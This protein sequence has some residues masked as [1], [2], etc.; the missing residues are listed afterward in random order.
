MER[1]LGNTKLPLL[2]VHPEQEQSGSI[3]EAQERERG[4]KG[5]AI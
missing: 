1:I 3:M 5:G 4:L 2:V